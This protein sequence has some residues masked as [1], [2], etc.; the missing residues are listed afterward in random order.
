LTKANLSKD[1]GLPE[2][3]PQHFCK[4]PSPPQQILTEPAELKDLLWE[5][6]HNIEA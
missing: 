5:R 4:H 2:L 3:K 6:E 1:E